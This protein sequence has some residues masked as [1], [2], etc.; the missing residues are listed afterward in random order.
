MSPAHGPSKHEDP[1]VKRVHGSRTSSSGGI[2][3]GRASLSGLSAMKYDKIWLRIDV[4]GLGTLSVL[5]LDL[6][7]LTLGAPRCAASFPEMPFPLSRSIRVLSKALARRVW[8]LRV[9]D[10]HTGNHLE[11]VLRHSKLIEGFNVQLG[12]DPIRARRGGLRARDEDSI[13][14]QTC[15]LSKEEFNDFLTL[16]PIPS[17]YRVIL[18]KSNQTIFVAPPGYAGLYT[19]SFSLANLRLPLT[20]FFYEVLKYF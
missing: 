5:L 18:P 15:E 2:S 10:S 13:A 7:P 11:I 3:V 16:Y 17:E 14:T 4:L 6:V 9:V 19:H 20:E 8:G 1:S 12:E